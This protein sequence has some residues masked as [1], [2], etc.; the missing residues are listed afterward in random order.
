MTD[1]DPNEDLETPPE[2]ESNAPVVE[3]SAEPAVDE[4]GYA[5]DFNGDTGDGDE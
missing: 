4:D 5:T 1:Y 3:S 2:D